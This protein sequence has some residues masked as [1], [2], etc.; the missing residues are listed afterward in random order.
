MTSTKTRFVVTA[1][2]EGGW[3]YG[4]N[5]GPYSK[6]HVAN[7]AK[8]CIYNN[9]LMPVTQKVSRTD[10]YWLLRQKAGLLIPASAR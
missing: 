3:D 5:R 9:R 10:G 7:G 6:F 8:Y 1:D 2:S 4:A